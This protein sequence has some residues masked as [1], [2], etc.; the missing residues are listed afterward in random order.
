M[1]IFRERTGASSRTTPSEKSH[2]D[3]SEKLL[4]SKSGLCCLSSDGRRTT[5][6]SP[7]SQYEMRGAKQGNHL[8]EKDWGKY[9][10]TNMMMLPRMRLFGQVH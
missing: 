1:I 3:C 6:P 8:N 9:A 2:H 4:N 7:K 10:Y 5:P